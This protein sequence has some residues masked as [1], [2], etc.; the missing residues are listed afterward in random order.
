MNHCADTKIG[1]AAGGQVVEEQVDVVLHKKEVL[2]ARLKPWIDEAYMVIESI[3]GKL[4]TLQATQ[5]KLQAY[6]SGAV[7]E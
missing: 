2:K 7:T 5:Q 3:E 6:S 4:V 1:K